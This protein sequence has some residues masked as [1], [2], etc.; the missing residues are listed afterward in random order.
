MKLNREDKKKLKKYLVQIG[1]PLTL[2]VIIIALGAKINEQNK[3]LSNERD[4]NRRQA[5]QITTLREI[6]NNIYKRK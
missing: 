4:T 6:I 1:V 3:A 5:I 2:T